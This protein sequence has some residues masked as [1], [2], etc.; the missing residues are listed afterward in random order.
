[1]QESEPTLKNPREA[2]IQMDAEIAQRMFEEE[3]AQVEREQR[4]ARE[5]VVEQEAKDAAL[6]D[7]ME[8][9]QGRM[10]ADT[11]LAPRE[12]QILEINHQP[13]LKSGTRW[14]QK[15]IDDFKPMDDSSSKPA[16]GSKKKTLVKSKVKK[17][18]KDEEDTVDPE[19]LSTK[20][21]IVDCESQ[22]LRNVD[23]EDLYVY[24][25][26]RADRNTSYHKSLSNTTPKGY[27]LLL[28]EDLKML[29]WKLEAEAE[30]TMAFELLKFIK[31]QL[32]E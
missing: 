16:R 23:M 2:Q 18:L 12:Q 4:S 15:W 7:Q 5:S 29:N 11:L 25:I 6:I 19:I 13:N 32:E 24:Q 17:V 1:M 30:S 21:P 20:Y 3:Q 26:I 9:I 8:D 22:I 14:E 10:E 31:S 28:W 27:N